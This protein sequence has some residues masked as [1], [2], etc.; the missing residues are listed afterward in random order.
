MT[1]KRICRNSF[2]DEM[3]YGLSKQR[4]FTPKNSIRLSAKTQFLQKLSEGM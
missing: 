3:L 4:R 1:G 2:T